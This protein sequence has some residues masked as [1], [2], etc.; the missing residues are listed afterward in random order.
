MLELEFYSCSFEF[1][2]FNIFHLYQ[3]INF[4]KYYL[5]STTILKSENI[6]ICPKIYEPSQPCLLSLFINFSVLIFLSISFKKAGLQAVLHYLVT[7]SSPFLVKQERVSQICEN[8]SRRHFTSFNNRIQKENFSC[9]QLWRGYFKNVQNV[10][11]R[12]ATPQPTQILRAAT[13]KVEVQQY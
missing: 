6:A 2:I 11:L 13:K 1:T 9:V 12:K 3:L 7:I 4:Q 10:N 5:H 8:L